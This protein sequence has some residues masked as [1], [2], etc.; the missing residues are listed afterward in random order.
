MSAGTCKATF[1]KRVVPSEEVTATGV[2]MCANGKGSCGVMQTLRGILKT[3]HLIYSQP[4]KIWP[5]QCSL[6]GKTRKPWAGFNC[7]ETDS[8]DIRIDGASGTFMD[9][10]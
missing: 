9:N 2:K 6:K 7:D 3:S 4:V 5:S 10:I 1:I 8:K